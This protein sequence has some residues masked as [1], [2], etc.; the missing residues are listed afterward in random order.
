[1][2]IVSSDESP[3]DHESCMTDHALENSE[4]STIDPLHA[5]QLVSVLAPMQESFKQTNSLLQNVFNEK[6]NE[7]KRSHS[8][9]L[10]DY[11]A[12]S[13]D[14]SSAP[15]RAKLAPKLGHPNDVNDRDLTEQQGTV[16][17]H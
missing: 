14:N 3:T 16:Q 10:D 4:G 1:M 7:G 12:D 6:Q 11:E 13:H 9:E 17:E 15:K 2:E 5:G 8:N